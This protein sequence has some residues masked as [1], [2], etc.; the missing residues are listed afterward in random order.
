MTL[1]QDLK[2]GTRTLVKS[3][4]FTAVAVAVLAL[5]VGANTA[6]FSVVNAV[7]LRPLPFPGAER[8]VD[9]QGVNPSKGITESNLSA[10]DFED[11]RAEQRSFEALALYTSFNVNMTGGDE[12][13]RVPATAVSAD[14]FRVMGVSAARGRALTAEDTELGRDPVAVISHGLWVRRFGADPS[15]V[16]R[17]VEISGRSREIVG[18]MPK[19]FDFPQHSE[20]WYPLPLDTA[21]QPRDNRSFQVIGRL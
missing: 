11:W 3:P 9:F 10:P 6:I 20:V 7:L 13:E 8:I 19:G 2:F 15:V 12:P 16:G 14:F 18:I 17:R 1:L 21:K 4:A 5:G